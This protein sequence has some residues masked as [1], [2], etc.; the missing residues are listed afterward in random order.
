MAKQNNKKYLKYFFLV[1]FLFM[2]V[3][4]F[5]IVKP[6][7]TTIIAAVILSYIFYPLYAKLNR[8]TKSRNISATIIILITILLLTIP[9]YFVVNTITKESYVVYLMAKQRISSGEVF[10]ACDGKENMLCSIS[11]FTKELLENPKTSY[12]LEKAAQRSTNFVIDS[13][14][15]FVF[16]IPAILLNFFIMIFIMFYLLK[17]ASL[18]YHKFKELIPLSK[19]HKERVLKKFND[20]TYAVVY[21]TLIIGLA[22]GIL[23]G[24]GLFI[25]GIPS[26]V[27]WGVLMIIASIIPFVG[28][29]VIWMP[30]AVFHILNALSLNDSTQVTKGIIMIIYFTLIVG[31]VDNILKPRIVGSRSQVHPVLVLLGVVG[32]I[33]F[34]GIIGVIIGPVILAIFVAFLQIYESERGSLFFIK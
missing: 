10:A 20:V 5:L 27:L 6:F 14:S 33:S 4:S 13:M 16:S 32:G 19:P 18:I 17:D 28:P 21:G 30:I 22:Q 7:L 3:L 11:D 12:H 1:I 34:F 31:T 15:N 29:P 25:F 24:L 26:P 9:F 23:G 2:L 8:K